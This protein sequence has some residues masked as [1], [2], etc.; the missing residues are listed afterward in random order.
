ML[1]TS[2]NEKDKAEF[3]NIINKNNDLLLHLINDILNLSKIESGFVEIQVK[4]FDLSTLFNEIFATQK[5]RCTNP[6]I[7]FRGN[8][9]YK[10][11]IINYDRD[12]LT[13]VWTNYISNALKYTSHANLPAS[14]ERE[15]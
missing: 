8:N 12:R 11:C 3:I 13:E 4:K 15:H 14:S 5:F 9:P 10:S 7:E 2:D 1:Q 6:D